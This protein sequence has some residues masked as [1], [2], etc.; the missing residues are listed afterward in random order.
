MLESHFNF[1]P[2]AWKT[3]KVVL[4]LLTVN[5]ISCPSEGQRS[6]SPNTGLC[7]SLDRD[8]PADLRNQGCT[9][10]WWVS[11]QRCR[12][13]LIL[14]L[15]LKQYKQFSKLSGFHFPNTSS[16][17]SHSRGEQ[18]V[19]PF[20]RTRKGDSDPGV[21]WE[22]R[23]SADP[24]LWLCAREKGWLHGTLGEV[25]PHTRQRHWMNWM[26]HT[27]P[28]Q[29]F[30]FQKESKIPLKK[31]RGV[32][33]FFHVPDSWFKAIPA[34]RNPR[35]HKL[36]PNGRHSWQHD[37]HASDK[38][39]YLEQS[40]RSHWGEKLVQITIVKCLRFTSCIFPSPLL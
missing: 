3:W 28:Q 39:K 36:F 40:P 20:S 4:A 30:N 9:G 25:L 6:V 38:G 2:L 21:L 7:H 31:F 1:R 19:V 14:P 12:H 18:D 32:N 22:V 27:H 37:C 23:V 5:S 8:E 13:K 35:T 24:R 10:P 33:H 17:P 26:L 16:V 34:L 11:W 29:G 15:S